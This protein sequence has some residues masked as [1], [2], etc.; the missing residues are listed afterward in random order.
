MSVAP[1]LPPPHEWTAEEYDALPA[2][3]VRR[4]LVEGV[5]HVSPSPTNRHQWV[6]GHLMVALGTSAPSEF[7]VTQAVEIKLG[8][9][10]RYIPDLLVVTAEA[11]ADGRR[12]QFLP[13]EVVLAGEIVSES[14]RSMDRVLK[15]NRYASVG[16]PHYWRIELEPEVTV[17]AYILDEQGDYRPVGVF[18]DTLELDAP[19]PMTIDLKRLTR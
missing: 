10:L 3:G 19:W 16:I 12:A 7:F 4:E 11:A 6:A 17:Y 15:P 2:D 13:Y 14:S 5:L 8:E 1:M 9:R 18:R